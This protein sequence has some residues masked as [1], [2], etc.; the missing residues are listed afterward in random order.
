MQYKMLGNSG[1]KVS[2]LCLGTMTFGTDFG[3]GA[4]DDV[5]FELYRKFRD[6]GGNFLDT[7]NTYTNGT[8]ER[9]IGDLI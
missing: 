6:A 3:W 8:S 4:A 2:E 7:A 9:L 1:L 5:C